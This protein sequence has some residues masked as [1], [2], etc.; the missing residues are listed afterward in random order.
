MYF[1]FHFLPLIIL[2]TF[3]YRKVGGNYDKEILSTEAL[4]G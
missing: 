3:A 1:L 4:Y 2:L